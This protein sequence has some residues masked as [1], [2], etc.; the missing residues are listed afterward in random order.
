MFQRKIF[1][2]SFTL[3]IILVNIQSMQCNLFILIHC[4]KYESFTLEMPD[5]GIDNLGVNR[6]ISVYEGKVHLLS[7]LS[8][9]SF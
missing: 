4:K 1:V 8:G 7:M 2:L 5:T 9:T 6:K 3:I